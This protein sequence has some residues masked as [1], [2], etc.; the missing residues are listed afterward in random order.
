MMYEKQVANK[1]I[2]YNPTFVKVTIKKALNI[3]LLVY[4]HEHT[5]RC[6]YKTVWVISKCL[7][8][9]VRK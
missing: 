9:E 2:Q 1:C 4:V 5:E 6:T 7:R 3:Y 8:Q